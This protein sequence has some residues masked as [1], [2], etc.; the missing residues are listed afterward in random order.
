MY[1]YIWIKQS[2]RTPW[3]F[4]EL[5]R[6]VK[7]CYKWQ[8]FIRLLLVIL[9]PSV[10]TSGKELPNSSSYPKLLHLH[11]TQRV[12][13]AST[14][15]SQRPIVVT[16]SRTPEETMAI[17]ANQ[18][19]SLSIRMSLL[20]PPLFSFFSNL[21][22][23]NGSGNNARCV[24]PGVQA[25]SDVYIVAQASTSE[26]DFSTQTEHIRKHSRCLHHATLLPSG[27]IVVLEKSAISAA[28]KWV[29]QPQRVVGT[30]SARNVSQSG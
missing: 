28:R 17:C 18:G 10:S 19:Y 4:Y 29:T 6:T 27:M 15:F 8:E 26:L 7:N 16:G 12:N 20:S 13:N 3:N 2:T 23:N 11:K 21:L 24:W 9:Q 25:A 1:V 14:L 30:H 5:S 22:N